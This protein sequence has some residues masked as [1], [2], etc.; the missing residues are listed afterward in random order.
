MIL[1]TQEKKASFNILYLG[2]IIQLRIQIFKKFKS[3]KN[4]LFT[5][6]IKNQAK[7]SSSYICNFKTTAQ[8]RDKNL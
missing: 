8:N 6:S 2:A 1:C 5:W 4:K 7:T 3:C